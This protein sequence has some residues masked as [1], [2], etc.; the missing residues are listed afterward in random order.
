MEDVPMFDPKSKDVLLKASENLAK[1]SENAIDEYELYL[2]DE[3]D[4]RKLA[5]VMTRLRS[6][7]AQYYAAGGK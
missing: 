4:W 7:L 1:S 6:T 5:K 3:T 2:L